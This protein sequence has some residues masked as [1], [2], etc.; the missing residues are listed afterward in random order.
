MHCRAP[1]NIPKYL[2]RFTAQLAGTGLP[3]IRRGKQGGCRLAR[4]PRE[5]TLADV[6]SVTEG[7]MHAVACLEGTPNRCARCGVC[8]TLPAWEGLERTV[9]N[10]LAP[11]TL[12]NLPD[13]A[14]P[15]PENAPP[16]AECGC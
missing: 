10:Y 14:K 4:A 16:I 5:V 12:Q 3:D 2:E 1:E 9:Q 15:Q 6:W 13:W 7:A 11:V 8:V